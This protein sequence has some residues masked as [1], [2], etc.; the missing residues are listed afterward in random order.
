MT[1]GKKK[2]T[3]LLYVVILLTII[4]G[5]NYWSFQCG[6][7]TLSSLL[8]FSEPALILIV[9]NLIG[10]AVLLRV[11]FRN[12]KRLQRHHCR[13]GSFLRD[14]WLF[15]PTCGEGRRA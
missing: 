5:Y 10:L 2:T 8:S 6:Y 14:G 13:C 11:K 3:F 9:C 15:C 1:R 4:V 12:R 7:C